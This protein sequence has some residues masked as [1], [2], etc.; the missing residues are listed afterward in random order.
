[1]FA[2]SLAAAAF[3]G[4]L[5]LGA[6]VAGSKPTY[7]KD[8]APIMNRPCVECHRAGEAAPMAFTN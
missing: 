7:T 8:I 4:G 1:M 6:N 5:L 3:A 2:R